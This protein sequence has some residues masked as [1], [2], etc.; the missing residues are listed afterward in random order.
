MNPVAKKRIQRKRKPFSV[1]ICPSSDEEDSSKLEAADTYRK[2]R[3]LLDKGVLSSM[4]EFE[5]DTEAELDA[6]I[7][8]YTAGCGWL[9]DGWYASFKN[10]T[11]IQ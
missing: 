10:K 4:S 9:G 8:G 2:L 7:E 1:I 11:Q 6:F 5:F 3:N